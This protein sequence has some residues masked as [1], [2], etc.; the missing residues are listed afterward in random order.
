MMPAATE[1]M[2]GSAP[3]LF[4]I[5][6]RKLSAKVPSLGGRIDRYLARAIV[7]PLCGTVVVTIL[8]LV[9]QYL[10]VLF[11]RT[12][13]G[14][15][16]ALVVWEMLG[17]LVPEYLDL[18]LPIGLLLGVL[19]AYRRLAL[20]QE[21]DAL[22]AC[23]FGPRR[24]LRVP[25]L[26]AVLVSGLTIAFS[27]FIQPLSIYRYDDLGFQAKIG[28]FGIPIYAGK[29]NHLTDNITVGVDEFDRFGGR[30]RGVFI[31]VDDGQAGEAAF[32]A[33]SGQF[34]RTHGVNTVIVRLFN[35][36]IVRTN[37]RL[38]NRSVTDFD[39]YD[40][41]VHMPPV[42]GFRGRGGRE[43]EMTLPELFAARHDAAVSPKLRRLADGEA[44][45]R[46]IL[47]LLPFVLPLLALA[48]ARPPQ[49][50][51]SSLGVI[52]GTLMIILMLKALDIGVK[53]TAFPAAPMLWGAFAVFCGVTARL[54]H[55]YAFEPGRYPLQ[56]LHD[57]VEALKARFRASR[58]SHH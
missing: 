55:I 23:G 27:G 51:T 43:A 21:L 45:R 37:A 7:V 49:R 1:R 5:D 50:S 53:A 26:F 9:L 33:Q 39:R 8:L 44:Q 3:E 38:T 36:R 19:L 17:Y 30:M 32:T 13:Q 57:L 10:P 40:L 24:L 35:G 20:N 46:V 42:E 18:G 2:L 14:G 29:F 15:G 6:P 16:G 22:G 47:A 48:L 56:P 54:H 28:A 11:D 58:W 25:Y 34:V 31:R 12:V 41:I 4:T 52:V